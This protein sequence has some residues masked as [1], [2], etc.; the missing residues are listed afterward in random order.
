MSAHPREHGVAENSGD[1]RGRGQRDRHRPVALRNV[2]W[3]SNDLRQAGLRTGQWLAP[4]FRLPGN[5][6]WRLKGCEAAAGRTPAR[7]QFT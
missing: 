1:E 4:A 6:Q 2:P 5:S 3:W 7:E